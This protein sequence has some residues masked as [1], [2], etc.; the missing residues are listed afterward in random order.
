MKFQ[1]NTDKSSFL[2]IA[3]VLFTY[4][5]PLH[6]IDVEQLDPVLLKQIIYNCKRG[7]LACDDPAKLLSMVPEPVQPV[8]TYTVPSTPPIVL[9]HPVSADPF[10]EDLKELKALLKQKVP[11]IKKA[12]PTL[13]I[14]RCRKLKELELEGR[15]RKGLLA[16]INTMLNKF[17]E[18][19]ASSIGTSDVGGKIYAPGVSGIGSTNVSDIVESEEVEIKMAAPDIEE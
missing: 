4:D 15:N 13:S 14:G 16:S 9:T 12:L 10:E 3:G 2:N 5:S 8:P 19:I 7:F 11:S 17:S 6:P 18:S 1:L